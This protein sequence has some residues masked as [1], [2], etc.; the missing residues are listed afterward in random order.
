MSTSAKFSSEPFN[1]SKA[2]KDIEGK[3]KEQRT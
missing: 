3:M 2:A 1:T